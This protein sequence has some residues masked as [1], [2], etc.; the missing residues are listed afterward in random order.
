MRQ[1]FS[2]LDTKQQAAPKKKLRQRKLSI[3][4]KQRVL[5]QAW[6]EIERKEEQELAH[7]NDEVRLCAA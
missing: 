1:Q 5:I 6:E 7:T 3:K 4:S 2:D